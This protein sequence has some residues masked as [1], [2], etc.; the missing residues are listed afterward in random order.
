MV[1]G[2]L[3]CLLA[4]S[5][6]TMW[7]RLEAATVQTNVDI[8]EP[9]VIRSPAR[10]HDKGDGFGWSAV[11]HEI[12]E[13]MPM[14]GVSQVLSK[15][16][17]IIGAP[18]GTFP[19]GLS[20]ADPGKRAENNTGLVYVCDVTGNN[21]GG[22]TGNDSVVS[23]NVD[24]R[25]Q[26]ENL[27]GVTEGR[28]FDQEAN[29]IRR[30]DIVE[31]KSGQL[32]GSTLYSSGRN[33]LACAPNWSFTEFRSLPFGICFFGERSLT[34]FQFLNP[35]PSVSISCLAGYSA[36]IIR[37]RVIITLP[38]FTGGI[39]GKWA[40]TV[41][42]SILTLHEYSYYFP[43]QGL[44]LHIGFSSAHGYISSNVRTQGAPNVIVGIPR[45]D[46]IRNNI[47]AV[48]VLG[49]SDL[50]TMA[51]EVLEGTQT[52]EFFGYCVATCDLNGDGYDDLL[53]GAP[54]YTSFNPLVPE[55]GRLYVYFNHRGR[56]NSSDQDVLVGNV[57]YGRF[58]FAVTNA[59]D[60][61]RDG[62]GDIVVSAAYERLPSSNTGV[63]YV[64]YGRRTI[65]EFV[66]QTPQRISAD[67]I[68]D[69]V[70][71]LTQ[72]NSFGFHLHGGKD[73][74]ANGYPDFLV[75][76]IEEQAVVV[77]RTLPFVT[78]H[79]NIGFTS[80]TTSP[81][82]QVTITARYTS[83][84]KRGSLAVGYNLTEISRLGP[85]HRLFFAAGDQSITS[86]AGFFQFVREDE[87]ITISIRAYGPRNG[88]LVQ[89]NQLQL[90]LIDFVRNLDPVSG[91][92]PISDLSA[93]PRLRLVGNTPFQV[94]INRCEGF[95]SAGCASDL[96]LSVSSSEK[97]FVVG[98][99]DPVIFNVS[100]S[101][102]GPE[103]SLNVILQ[104]LNIPSA[105]IEGYQL[106]LSGCSPATL[107]PSVPLINASCALQS[108]IIPGQ[109]F[110]SQLTF[111]PVRTLIGDEGS[112]T[113]TLR[114]ALDESGLNEDQN[115]SNNMQSVRLIVDSAVDISVNMMFSLPTFQYLA[116]VPSRAVG[117]RMLGNDALLQVTVENSGP[118]TIQDARLIIK[119][120]SRLPDVT[121]QYYFLYPS[122]F[123]ALVG[124]SVGTTVSC[125][126]NALD[127]EGLESSRD[128]IFE[129]YRRSTPSMFTN[130]RH[131]ARGTGGPE[132]GVQ[133]KALDENMVTLDCAE[134]TCDIFICDI[135]NLA[136][137]GVD[138][139]LR[140]NLDERF[141][142]RFVSVYNRST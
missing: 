46:G 97:I 79:V 142:S 139:I 18:Y 65:A 4:A 77:L 117:G 72:L 113:I 94:P 103:D 55:R 127:P 140:A 44:A 70:S 128:L 93:F 67:D 42:T 73:V 31:E 62:L 64:Y 7:V 88:I 116:E 10:N 21:C 102:S 15:T 54:M 66:N 120:P 125:S 121:G 27:T 107:N 61:D 126:L 69:S 6:S 91:T 86:I 137:E 75:G 30:S 133:L 130:S 28:L 63:V 24:S 43:S 58:G 47:G 32:M 39:S 14:D 52:A 49:S 122:T 95:G 131:R 41:A 68:T 53:V 34:N 56:I 74:D 106:A 87:R 9:S 11:F 84:S 50:Q 40:G 51:T 124:R 20:L 123:T 89:P 17:I 105:I 83:V 26:A 92:Q 134:A 22:V 109:Q 13:V 38:A 108:R 35:C 135:R 110:S 2:L 141:Y 114:I 80:D 115:R 81:S 138:F 119:F 98:S 129:R 57:A 99:G 29:G 82:F 85:P 59:G 100:Y 3:H 78:V 37:D 101:N 76:A 118:T 36:S 19:G 136:E 132:I 5:F 25:F 1:M 23:D 104:I 45:H 71:T 8:E 16:R 111:F 112:I 90:E 96:H 12:E 33:I 60:L 48:A